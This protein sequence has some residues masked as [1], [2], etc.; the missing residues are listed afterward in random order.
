MTAADLQNYITFLFLF[1]IYNRIDLQ[2][3]VIIYTF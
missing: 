1:I 2:K 3:S